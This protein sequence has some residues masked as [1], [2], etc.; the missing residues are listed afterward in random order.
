VF[1]RKETAEAFRGGVA[2]GDQVLDL[3][4][5]APHLDGDAQA[6]AEACAQP[7]LNALLELGPS[8]WRALRHGL[9]A[10]LRDDADGALV[11]ALHEAMLPL[12][13]IEHAL[14][15]RIGDYTDFYTSLDH[16]ANVGK[17]MS[18]PLPVTA[19]FRWLPI[20][21]HGRV[22]S[23]GVSGQRRLGSACDAHPVRTCIRR[24]LCSRCNRDQCQ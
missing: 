9:F 2:I 24:D 15:L 19:N 17:L 22:S 3:G 8:A 10:A 11:A 12:A 14:P 4:R 21:Y 13:D 5:A 18:P 1:R 7:T 6:A 16:A 23:I 20:A